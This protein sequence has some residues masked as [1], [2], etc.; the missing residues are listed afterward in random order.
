[1]TPLRYQEQINHSTCLL[2]LF[3]STTVIKLLLDEALMTKV[4]LL[5]KRHQLPNEAEGLKK[6]RTWY[7]NT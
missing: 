5:P 6:L 3:M 4:I 2:P 7:Q 1:M